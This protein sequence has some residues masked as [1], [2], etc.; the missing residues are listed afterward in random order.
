MSPRPGPGA[1][2]AA[3]AARRAPGHEAVGREG[4]VALPRGPGDC[5][6][7]AGGK[8]RLAG[9][10]PAVAPAAAGS[11]DPV[12]PRPGFHPVPWPRWEWAPAP[13]AGVPGARRR[14]GAALAPGAGGRRRRWPAHV[15]H[16]QPDAGE[17]EADLERHDEGVVRERDVRLLAAGEGVA[18]HAD[19]GL[20]AAIG[21]PRGWRPAGANAPWRRPSPS[22]RSARRAAS[23]ADGGVPRIF[24]V[25]AGAVFHRVHGGLGV[26]PGPGL[27][28]STCVA[29]G[30]PPTRAA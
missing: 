15:F 7:R 28:C 27:C 22:F 8:R 20:G 25:T 23:P 5:R 30:L 3:P 24:G 26:V 9:L 29:R 12:N 11:R 14:P 13:T 4:E 6:L 2:P 1:G 10:P 19:D 16:G 17:E 18:L 21:A